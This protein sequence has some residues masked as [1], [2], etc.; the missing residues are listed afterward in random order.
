MSA[1]EQ[2]PLS[3]NFGKLPIPQVE[4]FDVGN[5]KN[6]LHPKKSST[7]LSRSVK[8]LVGMAYAA[9]IASMQ[10]GAIGK[11]CHCVSKGDMLSGGN[12][13][14]EGGAYQFRMQV[15]VYNWKFPAYN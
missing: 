6:D 13:S 15:F 11:N 14:N 3:V 12:N 9:I 5:G 10:V 8:T 1:D 2:G 7:F 4:N